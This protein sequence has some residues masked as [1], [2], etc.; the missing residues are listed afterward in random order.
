MSALFVRTAKSGAYVGF[1]GYASVL[2]CT[3]KP[4]TDLQV[5]A[6]TGVH[7]PYIRR[8]LKQF[9][10][11]RLVHRVGWE[12][13]PRGVDAPIYLIGPG[14]NVPPRMTVGGRPMPHA[15]HRHKLQERVVAFAS[16]I[17]AL[18]DPLTLIELERQSGIVISRLSELTRHLLHADIRL[19]YVCAWVWR[20][21][22]GGPPMRVFRYGVDL[23][24]ARRPKRRVQEVV[25]ERTQRDLKLTGWDR[26]VIALKR[27]AGF[28]AARA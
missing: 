16:V 8:L 19:I 18:E 4:V 21:T 27:N 25:R 9:M 7:H 28:Q 10:A 17:H 26:T 23:P 22:P 13:R 3:K 1:A 5:S 12:P 6:T 15:D 24:D 20:D 11:L 2:A 14:E